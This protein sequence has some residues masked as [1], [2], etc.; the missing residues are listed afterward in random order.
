MVDLDHACTTTFRTWGND[1]GGCGAGVED[2]DDVAQT[3]VVAL[4][5]LL[6]LLFVR[7]SQAGILLILRA[8]V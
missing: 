5:Q 8:C 2:R 6:E 7:S 3:L 1:V 4:H